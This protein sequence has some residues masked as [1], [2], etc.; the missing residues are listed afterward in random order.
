MSANG[1]CFPEGV[2]H[3]FLRENEPDPERGQ[4]GLGDRSRRQERRRGVTCCFGGSRPEDTV[5]HAGV[6][7]H[8]AVERG[9]E[10]VEEG[11]AAESRAGGWGCVGVARDAC[12]SAEQSFDL[13]KKDLRECVDGS[14]SV[15][16]HA[17][18]S[19]GHGDHP[20]PHGRRRDDVI[21]KMRG[22]LG[23]V[24]AVAGRADAAAPAGEDHDE[25]R[26]ARHADCAGEAE[27]EEPALEIAA[28]FVLD[29]SRHGPLGGF[30]PLEPAF[31][32]RQ[33]TV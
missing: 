13:S 21:D 19:L 10:A 20:L 16:K 32:V 23:H 28:E 3:V 2:R 27:A 9:A 25:S 22:R 5:G 14:G 24:A 11:D 6:Q 18:Q 31:E 8:V 12:R 26:A 1:A 33:P 4:I 15:G 29:V 17:P 7:V 30:A